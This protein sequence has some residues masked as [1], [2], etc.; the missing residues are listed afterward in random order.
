[1]AREN[2]PS[3]IFID[4]I[5]AIC[6][7]RGDGDSEASRRIKTELLV[8][9][10]G[11]GKDT[12]GVLVLGATNIPWHLDSAI[13]RRFQR[14]VHISLPDLQARIKMFEIAISTTP[15]ELTSKDYRKMAELS[16]GYSGSDISIAV[17]D[18]LMSPIRKIQLSTHY[19]KVCLKSTAESTK[20]THSKKTKSTLISR[21]R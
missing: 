5:D 1:M 11:V 12:K 18:A 10:N 8:Q 20:K 3:I 21:R 9:M 19:K 2:K 6:G 17:Q 15:C 16:E 4:E 13:R 14:R 7:S